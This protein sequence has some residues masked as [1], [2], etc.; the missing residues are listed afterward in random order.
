MLK[1][2]KSTS[3]HSYHP[4]TKRELH[5][6]LGELIDERGNDADLNDID[7]SAITD[8][9]ALF[10]SSE[11]NGNIS[12]WDVSNVTSMNFMFFGS[13]FN[14]DISQWD[15]SNVTDMRY[16]FERSEFNQNISKWNVNKKMQHRQYV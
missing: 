7:T 15:V 13:K 6:I 11:F 1:I 4:K 5:I 12:G 3:L 14:S 8:M 10:Q 2:S 16:M 9:Q